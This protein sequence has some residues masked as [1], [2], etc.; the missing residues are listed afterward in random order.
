MET[1]NF[2]QS[3][4]TK[5]KALY[6]NQYIKNMNNN[7]SNDV[8]FGKKAHN[9]NLNF[10]KAIQLRK[11]LFFNS[12]NN[13]IIIN[14]SKKE[15]GNENRNVHKIDQSALKY[16]M[17][18]YHLNSE[19]VRRLKKTVSLEK[20]NIQ[21]F[22]TDRDK[23]RSLSRMFS[24]SSLNNCNNFNNQ[25]LN[26]ISLNK[27][28]KANE[29]LKDISPNYEEPSKPK[30]LI[31]QKYL[32][33][34]MKQRSSISDKSTQMQDSNQETISYKRKR[35]AYT[36]I[37]NTIILPLRSQYEKEDISFDKREVNNLAASN[38]INT[39]KKIYMKH[40]TSNASKNDL[41]GKN[42]I[43]LEYNKTVIKKGQKLLNNLYQKI[44][45]KQHKIRSKENIARKATLTRLSIKN[46]LSLH[47]YEYQILSLINNTTTLEI[48]HF[49]DYNDSSIELFFDE[50]ITRYLSNSNTLLP[51]PI[52]AYIIKQYLKI[53]QIYLSDII[54]DNKKRNY[55]KDM[56]FIGKK[57]SCEVNSFLPSKMFIQYDFN[58]LYMQKFILQDSKV[59]QRKQE[60]NECSDVLFQ[61]KLPKRCKTEKMNYRKPIFSKNK[62][63]NILKQSQFFA[64]V[65][66]SD[67]KRTLRDVNQESTPNLIED[68]EYLIRNVKLNDRKDDPELFFLLNTYIFSLLQRFNQTSKETSFINYHSKYSKYFSIDTQNSKGDTLLILAVK[69]E[70]SKIVEYLLSKGANPNVQNV[71]DAFSYYLLIEI[72]QYCIA[73]CY[74]K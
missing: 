70:T 8:S 9:L 23:K 48:N 22:N 43:C 18:S 42:N 32:K 6:M 47:K 1:N 60:V 10:T 67:S 55:D 21:N 36:E 38:S 68:V 31:S 66:Q 5:E 61:R 7:M 34:F 11:Q 15:K 20:I 3:I 40:K 71:S 4:I 26:K 53:N 33:N 74:L 41:I 59:R 29:S 16:L 45:L 64:C 28:L 13:Q 17:Q 52:G 63:I 56:F 44:N 19:E 39:I 30:A 57:S 24:N 27:R 73:L 50:L 65:R 51:Y 14:E 2:N 35:N 46:K 58:V 25:S 54:L 49:D 62:E 37:K 12:I 69:Q 72:L